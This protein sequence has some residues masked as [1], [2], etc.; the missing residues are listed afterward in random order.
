MLCNETDYSGSSEVL[1]WRELSQPLGLYHNGVCSASSGND[2]CGLTRALVESFVME[3]GLPIYAP[4]SGYAGDDYIEDVP[5]G[6]DDRLRLWFKLP[7]Q[8]NVLWDRDIVAGGYPEEPPFPPI[9]LGDWAKYITGYTSRKGCSM[10]GNQYSPRSHRSWLP[11]PAFRSAEAMLNYIEAC[12]EK[13]G[14]LDATADRYWRAL[15]TRAGVDPDYTRTIAATDMAKEAA[16][17]NLAVWSGSS[18]VDA[19]LFNIRRER[20]S[21][22]W[23]E[24]LRKYDIRRW[25]SLDGLI[26]KP[27]HME[28]FKIW[29]PMKEQYEACIPLSPDNYKPLVYDSSSATVSS[30][31][32]SVYLRPFQIVESN[33]LYNGLRWKMAWYLSPIG[34]QRFVDLTP[35]GDITKSPLYQNPGWGL[36]GGREASDI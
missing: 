19:T 10:Y 25:R 6:R 33:V 31:N 32:N 28:G 30:P 14:S 34:L 21:E 3:N 26:T 9:T 5:K 27:Y 7:N 17:G 13:N 1:M 36:E 12:Y 35:D 4:G 15:R 23:G 11:C 18:M 16:T 22:M 2:A 8:V 29:G 20:N 24:D